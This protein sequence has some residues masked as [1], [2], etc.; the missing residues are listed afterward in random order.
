MELLIL[1]LIWMLPL[2]SGMADAA[3]RSVIKVA[4][5]L[6]T[7]TLLSMGFFFALPLYAIWLY[8]TGM[9]HI[10]EKF[11]IAIALHVPLFTIATVL[12]VEAHKASPLA[13]TMPYMALT[14]AFLL[15]V[16]PFMALFFS[17]L[18]ESTPTI[19]GGIGVLI[20]V[21]GLYILNMQV[22]RRSFF[23]PI[24]AFWYDRGSRLM[25]FASIVLAFTS[26]LDLVALRGLKGPIHAVAPFYLL[27]DHALVSIIMGFMILL[28]LGMGRK[29][30]LPFSPSGFWMK[31]AGYG[32]LVALSVVPHMLV[33][34]W[35]SVVPYVIAVKRTGAILFGVLVLG[36]IMGFLLNHPDFQQEKKNVR[37]SI[38]GTCT[39]VLGMIV[40][41]LWGKV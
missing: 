16:T 22:A 20:L 41:I 29:Q 9:P 2:G 11:W 15:G 31:L 1:L 28:Y 25:F 6:H 3:S 10:E 38:L 32:F 26:V 36:L 23:D 12:T 40:I 33:F 24:R 8:F 35:I 5:K 14:P 7:F 13:K 19:I 4:K 39:A 18:E 27:V 21:A 17:G 37:Y 34:K 30:E